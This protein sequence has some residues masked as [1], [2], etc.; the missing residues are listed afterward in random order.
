MAGKPIFKLPPAETL[1]QMLHERGC[2]Q[3]AREFGMSGSALSYRAKRMGL[4]TAKGSAPD[5]LPGAQ[6]L[7]INDLPKGS[8]LSPDK[9]LRRVGLD[10][11]QWIVTAVKAR[12]GT[13]GNPEAPNEQIRLEVSVRPI[14]GGLKLPEIKDWKPLPKPK[15]RKGKGPKTAIV[16]GDHHA[17]H[18]DRTLHRL[19][20]TFLT[21]EQPDLIEVNGDLLDFADISRH[22]Q[23]PQTGPGGEYPFT[24]TVNECLQAGFGILLDYRTACPNATIRLKFGNHDMRLYYALVDNLKGLYSITAADDEV[25][26]LSLRKLLRLDELHVDLIEKDWE[27][28]KTRIG[29]RLTALHGYSTSKNPGGKMLTDLSGSTV[30]GHSHRVS[31]LYRTAHHPDNGTET[32]LAGEHGCMCEIDEGLG[33][34]NCPDWQQ[35]AMI[36]KTWDDNDFTVAPIIYLPGRLLLPDGRR[37]T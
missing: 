10:P 22:R 17:P 6:T 12:E 34:A 1:Q 29:R 15:A 36:V 27:K 11:E 31:L 14:L 2:E 25:P 7:T 9:L 28:A 5:G 16:C 21:D 37:Y 18:H 4:S 8:D 3:V 26:A 30:Q 13:W 23:M 32:R 35:G 19:F 24:N 20:C 33:Y